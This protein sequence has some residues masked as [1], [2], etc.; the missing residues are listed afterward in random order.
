MPKM[1]EVKCP[2]CQG[3]KKVVATLADKTEV[4]VNCQ[5][6]KGHGKIRVPAKE[7]K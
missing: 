5:T 3:E 2:S 7:A 1:I 4:K 6:C